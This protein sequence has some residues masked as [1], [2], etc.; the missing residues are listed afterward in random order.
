MGN[1][2][3]ASR[4][5]KSL[6]DLA[7]EKNQLDMVFNDA[8][9]FNEVAKNHDFVLLL[10]S[11]VVGADKKIAIFKAIFDGKIADLTFSFFKIVIEKGR[12]SFLKDIMI[13]IENQFNDLKGIKNVK[14][15][16]AVAVDDATIE[17]VKNIIQQTT[18]L[19]NVNLK[20]SVNEDLIGGFVLEYD[21][22]LFDASIANDIKAIKKQFLTNDFI[23]KV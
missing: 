4:Y 15:T 10:R 21:D 13:E 5:A 17:K 14:F 12:E 16:S 22:K 20:A 19:K 1:I 23:K 2:K 6:I 18:T 3:L 7:K 9:C 11:P 8:L